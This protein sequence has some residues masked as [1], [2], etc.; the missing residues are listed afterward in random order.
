LPGA[1]ARP[2]LAPLSWLALALLL[3][4]RRW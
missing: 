1:P 3:R 4:R 2:R